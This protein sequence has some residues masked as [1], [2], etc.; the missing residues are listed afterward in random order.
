MQKD[1]DDDLKYFYSEVS[2]D[3]L[4]LSKDLRACSPH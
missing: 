1:C 3:Y 4:A 2:Y